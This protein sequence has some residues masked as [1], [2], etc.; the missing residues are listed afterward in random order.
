MK[1]VFSGKRKLEQLRTCQTGEKLLMAAKLKNDEDILLHISD[2]PDLFAIE[3]R[4]HASCYRQYT[5]CLQKKTPVSVPLYLQS[6]ESFC[7]EVIESRILHQK[8]ILR[9]SDLRDMLQRS[10]FAAEGLDAGQ[11]LTRHLKKQLVR[12][13]GDRLQFVRWHPQHCE[14]VMSSDGEV[15]VFN[16][17]DTG[18]DNGVDDSDDDD[19]FSAG[20]LDGTENL[21]FFHAA[22]QLRDVLNATPGLTVWPPE[23]QDVT[24]SSCEKFVPVKLFNFLAWS[25]GNCKEFVSTD[26]FVPVTEESKRKLLSLAQDLIHVSSRGRKITPKHCALGMTLRHVTGSSK[27]IGLLN[28]LG[29]SMSHSFVLEHDTALAKKSLNSDGI[30]AG[31]KKG[32]FTTLVWDNNDFGEETLTGRGTTHNTNGIILQTAIMG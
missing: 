22:M 18:T 16:V 10:I 31:F 3:V 32:D 7:E 28:G 17:P 21:E 24:K 30:P 5:R 6:F 20:V 12:K 2:A 23:E 4:Y 29:H 1:D 13:Y 9:I 27:V 19:D 14:L 15:R 25:T 8:E 26:N 11:Y